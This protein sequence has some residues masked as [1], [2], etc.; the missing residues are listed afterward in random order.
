MVVGGVLIWLV[1]VGAGWALQQE[2][3]GFGDVTLMAMIGAF[4]GWQACVVIFFLAP[5]AALVYAILQRVLRRTGAIPYGPF[6]CLATLVT[7]WHWPR[8]WYQVIV[9]FEISWLVPSVLMMGMVMIAGMLLIWRQLR[10][11]LFGF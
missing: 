1:R 10:W 6:L 9:Y 11:R 3:M 2:A 7:L 4:V 5:F 8:L